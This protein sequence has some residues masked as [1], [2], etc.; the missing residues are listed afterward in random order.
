MAKKKEQAPPQGEGPPDDLDEFLN[1]KPPAIPSVLPSVLIIFANNIP[2]DAKVHCELES[3]AKYPDGADE[4]SCRRHLVSFVRERLDMIA[5]LEYALWLNGRLPFVTPRELLIW[6]LR[7]LVEYIWAFQLPADDDLSM[8][9]N[10]T[11]T[12]AANIAADF[13]ARFRKALLFPVALRRLY[14]ILREQDPLYRVADRNYE[15][16]NALG[17]TIRVPSIR[18]LQDTNTLVEEFRLREGGGFLRYAA[19]VF[20]EE[21]IIWVSERVLTLALDDEIKAELLEL[22]RIPRDSGY[23]G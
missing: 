10:T 20:K 4:M 16:K 8:I 18:Y 1:M 11:K 3:G 22:Y 6:R 15:Y 23:G 17:C 2:E 21:N 19:L 14:R 9:F 7:Q 12:R 13:T 5:R